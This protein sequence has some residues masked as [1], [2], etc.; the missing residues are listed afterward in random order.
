MNINLILAQSKFTESDKI[1][2]GAFI[3]ALTCNMSIVSIDYSNEKQ[4][5]MLSIYTDHIIFYFGKGQTQEHTTLTSY[6]MVKEVYTEFQF[7]TSFIPTCVYKY[8]DGKSLGMGNGLKERTRS[9]I[10]NTAY[11]DPVI[12]IDLAYKGSNEKAKEITVYVQK[13]T[14]INKP[15]SINLDLINYYFSVDVKTGNIMET[16][17]HGGK[18]YNMLFSNK[19]PNNHTKYKYSFE[20]AE[21]FIGCFDSIHCA[22]NVYSGKGLD[23]I[24]NF[25]ALCKMIL[26]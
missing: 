17:A 11:I 8:K 10:Y 9:I 22:T 23:G 19:Q 3:T 24:K 18:K 16:H 25:A 20:L 7:F 4:Y 14:L 13:T 6:D 12:K 5:E 26:I 15:K 1:K 2:I 21:T